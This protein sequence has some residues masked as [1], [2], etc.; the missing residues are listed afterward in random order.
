MRKSNIGQ[1]TG[2]ANDANRDGKIEAAAFLTHVGGRQ[3]DG[4][5]PG[6]ELEI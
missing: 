6:R 4:D 1:L 2:S 3:V 5:A